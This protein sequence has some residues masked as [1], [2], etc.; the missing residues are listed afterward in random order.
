MSATRNSR[1][2]RDGS[3]AGVGALRLGSLFIA[4]PVF[5]V[6]WTVYLGRMLPSHHESSH[7]DIAWV[8]FDLALAAALALVG[9]AAACRSVW[10]EGAAT[11][12]ATLLFVDAWFDVLTAGTTSER[13]VALLEAGLVEIP[14]GLLCLWLARSARAAA[15]APAPRT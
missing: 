13:A 4:A 14:F 12:A 9:I 11:A 7:W 15:A 10:L 5:L 8:G 2:R 3:F 6:P 1:L